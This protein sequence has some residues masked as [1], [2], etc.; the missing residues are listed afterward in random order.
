MHETK[1]LANNSH[2]VI[3]KMKS[4]DKTNYP[5]QIETQPYTMERSSAHI[6]PKNEEKG[7]LEAKENKE[8]DY[9]VED[10]D[11]YDGGC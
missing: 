1:E 11:A 2:E 7:K 4:K 10:N 9:T 5:G 8:E 6:N 3:I